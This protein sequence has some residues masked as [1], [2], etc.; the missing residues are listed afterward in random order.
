MKKT[1]S[2]LIITAMLFSCGSSD[3][4]KAAEQVKEIQ[5][6]IKP[7]AVAT[8]AGAFTMKAKLD[9]KDWTANSMM[10]PD[11]ASGIVGYY[12]NEYIGLPYSKSDM[13]TGKKIIL[14][15]DNAA[16]L[17]INNG[18][19]WKDIKGE[20]EITKADDDAAEGKFFFTAVC[21]STSKP[22]EV[23]DGFFRILLA[24]N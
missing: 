9:G 4:N 17:A 8:S 13:V 12:K 11:A 20:I 21:T 7:G 1:I 3:Q 19:L 10:P 24:K 5:S 23:T 18:C 6:A 16:D 2:I 14:G 22:I 15:E